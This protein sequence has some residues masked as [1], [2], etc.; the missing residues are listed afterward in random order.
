[1]TV[2][3][4]YKPRYTRADE[5]AEKSGEPDTDGTRSGDVQAYAEELEVTYAWNR[6]SLPLSTH[7]D[8]E[9]QAAAQRLAEQVVRVLLTEQVAK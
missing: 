9:I 6:S 2:D 5:R 4:P 1:M 8:A 3:T 7:T